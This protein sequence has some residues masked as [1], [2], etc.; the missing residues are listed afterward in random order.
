MLFTKI[1]IAFIEELESWN[2]EIFLNGL[3]A[4]NC[5]DKSRKECHL[6]LSMSLLLIYNG[7]QVTCKWLENCTYFAVVLDYT[8]ATKELKFVASFIDFLLP[9]N[10]G[11]TSF[12]NQQESTVKIQCCNFNISYCRN[13]TC[14]VSSDEINRNLNWFTIPCWNNQSPS[15]FQL[16][17]IL[18]KKGGGP[19]W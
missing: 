11:R 18:L 15:L 1:Q 6:L 3:S 19:N 16:L 13:N 17:K 9:E 12:R 10:F 14:C 5:Q 4:R 7:R 2:N 8:M